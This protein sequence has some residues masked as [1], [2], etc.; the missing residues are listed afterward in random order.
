MPAFSVFQRAMGLFVS[1]SATS[2][3]CVSE[4]TSSTELREI[5]RQEVLLISQIRLVRF[6]P[7]SCNEVKHLAKAVL[8]MTAQA[9][10]VLTGL[11]N[12]RRK[13]LPLLH[14]F[15]FLSSD[16][17][18]HDI[19]RNLSVFRLNPVDQI[20]LYLTEGYKNCQERATRQQDRENN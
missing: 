14:L 15:L 1:T 12:R 19:C 10:C 13:I 16:A 6:L 8:T 11:Q 18:F 4:G 9:L 20:Q 2:C 5:D 3:S 17:N 7:S